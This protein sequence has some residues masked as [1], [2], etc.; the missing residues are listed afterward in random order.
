MCRILLVEDESIEREALKI[1][2]SEYFN[3]AEIVG[4]AANSDEAIAIIDAKEIDLIFMDINIPGING[5]EVSKYV[6]NKYPNCSIIITTAHDEFE[7]AHTAIK[8]HVDDYLLK[9]IRKEKIKN[10]IE[11]YG[12]SKPL[13]KNDRFEKFITEISNDI[14]EHKYFDTV[15]KSKELIDC[16]YSNNFEN[17]NN[18]WQKTAEA[19]SKLEETTKSLKLKRQSNIESHALYL[20]NNY[21]IYT[22]KYLVTQTFIDFINSIFNEIYSMDN[23]FNGNIEKIAAYVHIHLKNNL[24]LE[25]ISDFYNVSPYYMSKLFKKEIG[26]NF[27][28]YVSNKKIEMAKEL[29]E[30]TDDRIVNIA[31]NL[32]FSEPNYFSKVF[33]KTVGK[34]PTAYRNEIKA[35]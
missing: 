16:I 21:K 25:E 6:K 29:L 35:G 19:V 15:Y 13:K 20:K 34:S 8:I 10:A 28:E 2:I 33:K 12:K 31:L 26:T 5:L 4:E 27:V 7:F 1:I 11:I 23:D 32:G 17:L 18:L 3:E 14:L 30:Y 9:P 22:N 24:S